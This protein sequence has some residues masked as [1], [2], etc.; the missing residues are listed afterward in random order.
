MYQ[1][2]RKKFHSDQAIKGI[3]ASSLVIICKNTSPLCI[4]LYSLFYLSIQI[5]EQKMGSSVE[6]LD[7]CFEVVSKIVQQC[8]DVR[9][10]R[11]FIQSI[12]L[13]SINLKKISIFIAVNC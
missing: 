11:N 6:D 5:G 12:S 7:K 2:D 1:L 4:F 13:D 8:G 3:H 9:I 10:L